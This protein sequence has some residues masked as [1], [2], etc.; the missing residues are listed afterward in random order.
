MRWFFDF[1]LLVS[2]FGFGLGRRAAAEIFT[3]QAWWWVWI[4]ILDYPT[5]VF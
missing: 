2:L 5:T 1:Y 4:W 3:E